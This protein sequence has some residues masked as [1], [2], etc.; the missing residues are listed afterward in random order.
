MSWLRPISGRWLRS[1][2]GW[3]RRGRPDPRGMPGDVLRAPPARPIDHAQGLVIGMASQGLKTPLNASRAAQPL[4]PAGGICALIN[5]FPAKRQRCYDLC[6]LCFCESWVAEQ[7][8]NVGGSRQSAQPRA[9]PQRRNPR[10]R[11]AIGGLWRPFNYN[12]KERMTVSYR[13]PSTCANAH[14]IS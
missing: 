5:R 8:S 10:S 1:P 2:A 3:P 4:R 6:T 7:Q 12:L 13:I 9:T 14:V 11:Q